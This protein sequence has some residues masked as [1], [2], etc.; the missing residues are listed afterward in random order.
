MDIDLVIGSRPGVLLWEARIVSVVLVR[1]RLIR[2]SCW[3]RARPMALNQRRPQGNKFIRR[4][5]PRRWAQKIVGRFHNLRAIQ[6]EM[7]RSQLHDF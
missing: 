3:R 6:T 4:P 1:R 2:H 7:K 5:L